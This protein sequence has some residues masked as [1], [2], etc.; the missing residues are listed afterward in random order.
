LR[1]KK[2]LEI[3]NVAEKYLGSKSSQYHNSSNSGKAHTTEGVCGV[4]I[5]QEN[6]AYSIKSGCTLKSPT[7]TSLS[8]VRKTILIQL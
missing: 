8:K 6:A 2:L 3:Q 7:H 4:H 5:T 1:Y